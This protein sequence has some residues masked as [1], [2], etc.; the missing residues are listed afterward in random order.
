[1]RPA[2]DVINRLLHDASLATALP[3]IS[4][5]YIDRFAGVM[6][7]PFLEF[8]W[9]DFSSL[10]PFDKAI[11]AIPKHRIVFFKYKT[12]D[13]WNRPERL[14]HVFIGSLIEKFAEIDKEVREMQLALSTAALAA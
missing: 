6:T 3:F 7:R 10:D 8:D 9:S 5:G 4:V 12:T 1:M 13:I 11:V 2:H 14:D